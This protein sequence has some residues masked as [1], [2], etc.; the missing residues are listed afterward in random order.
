[1]EER[2]P[3]VVVEPGA[4]LGHLDDVGRAD[5]RVGFAASDWAAPRSPRKPGPAW[6]AAAPVSGASG[7]AWTKTTVIGALVL[8]S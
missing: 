3:G 8:G 7:G 5:A 2:V 4:V 6:S 1:M